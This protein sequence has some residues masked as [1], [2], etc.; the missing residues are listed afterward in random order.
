MKSNGKSSGVSRRAVA[1]G[2]PATAALFSVVAPVTA[3]QAPQKPNVVFI[4]ADNVGYGDLGS[5]GGGQLRRAATPRLDQ[6]TREGLR[7]TQ[8]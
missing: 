5:Y 8:F 6:L 1:L 3:Q 7:L 4:L 2:L